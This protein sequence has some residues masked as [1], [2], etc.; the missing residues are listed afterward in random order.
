MTTL[1]H[2]RS[3]MPALKNP[4]HEA[5]AQAIFV[6]IF[7]PDLYPT[8]G[9]AYNAAGYRAKNARKPGGAAEAN[10]SR[11]LKNAKIFDRIAELQREAAEDAKETVDKCVAE[12]NQLRA[13]SHSDK[14][15]GAAVSAV[16]G[17][18][19]L[20]G[21][22]TERHEDVTGKPDFSKAT[23]LEDV[24]IKLLQSVGY[25]EPSPADVALA[26]EA[27]EQMIET[28]EAIAERAQSLSAEQ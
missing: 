3:S 27:H 20:L 21:L 23:S 28:L 10:A 16:M 19:K 17:K 15:Y 2:Q 4:R 6:G 11:L 8:H 25:A 24:G 5:F 26:L 7:R 12:L 14:A 9:T 1:E 18:A 13:D 22:V